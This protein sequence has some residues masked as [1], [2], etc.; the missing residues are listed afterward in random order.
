M[1]S[2][3]CRLRSTTCKQGGRDWFLS[4]DELNSSFSRV[5]LV[6]T[7]VFSGVTGGPGLR[8]GAGPGSAGPPPPAYQP[9][10]INITDYDGTFN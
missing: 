2:P 6:P 1:T 5:A 8:R 3:V 9:T 10:T 7:L 4:A